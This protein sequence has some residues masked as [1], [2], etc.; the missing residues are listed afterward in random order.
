MGSAFLKAGTG[1]F[2]Q[3][4]LHCS[5]DLLPSDPHHLEPVSTVWTTQRNRFQQI[6]NKSSFITELGLPSSVPRYSRGAVRDRKE[7]DF[8]WWQCRLE[9]FGHLGDGLIPSNWKL[10][11]KRIYNKKEDSAPIWPCRKETAQEQPDEQW[12]QRRFTGLWDWSTEQHANTGAWKCLIILG[13]IQMWLAEN[14]KQL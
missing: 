1:D 7:A 10:F 6:A 13:L 12:L 4:Q 14:L 11:F 2:Q 9:A 8:F 3:P 5:I